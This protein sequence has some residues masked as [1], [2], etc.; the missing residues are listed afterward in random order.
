MKKLILR[1]FKTKETIF[2]GGI[3]DKNQTI[4]AISKSLYR[5]VALVAGNNIIP[6][7]I[8]SQCITSFEEVNK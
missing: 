6:Y 3:E 8:V 4:E 5:K 7:E 1:H 2:E